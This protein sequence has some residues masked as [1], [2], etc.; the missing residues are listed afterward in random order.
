MG[1][2][3]LLAPFDGIV[4]AR[5]ANTW[6]FVL[7]STGDPTAEMRSPDLS[8]GGQAAPIYVVDRTDIVRIFVDIPERDANYVHIGSEARVKIWA[9]R[10]EWLPATVTRLSWALNTQS[11]TMRAEIDLPNTGSQILPGMYAYGEVVVERPD[12]RALPKAAFTHAGGKSFIWRYEK[13]HAARTEVQTG[14]TDG[15]WIEVTNRRV[16]S[17]SSDNERWVPIDC[18]RNRCSWAA[19][20]RP[21]PTAASCGS[22]TRPRP[23]GRNPTTRS[24]MRWMPASPRKTFIQEKHENTR[25]ILAK[26]NFGVGR[27]IDLGGSFSFFVSFGVFRG[28]E[29]FLRIC[30]VAAARPA[31]WRGMTLM[32]SRDQEHD[33]RPAAGSPQGENS[34]ENGGPSATN[35]VIETDDP[36]VVSGAAYHPDRIGH[37]RPNPTRQKSDEDRDGSGKRREAQRHHSPPGSSLIR[38]LLLPGIVSLICGVAGAWA[39]W[40]FFGAAKSGDQKNSSK[41]SDSGDNSDSAEASP[42]NGNLKQVEANWKTAL[43]ERDQAQAD[44][45]EARRTAA[46]TNA[47]LDFLKRKLLSAGRPGEVSLS[48]VFWAGGQGKD[49]S[50]RKAVDAAASQVAEVLADR[51][52]AEASVREILGMTYLN[53]GEPAQAVKQYER[54]LALREAMQGV[55]HPDTAEC[56]NRLA[57]AYR[58]ANRTAEAGRLLDRNLSSPAHAS[59]LAISGSMLLVEKKPA[60]AELKLRESLTIREK[61]QPDDWET[62]DTKSLL[63]EALV[64]QSK[65]AEAEPLLL[66]GYEGLKQR[67]NAISAPYKHHVTR[68]LERLVKLYETWGEPTKAAR[69]RNA[70]KTAEVAKKS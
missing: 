61:I 66:S 11:R 26:F 62:F 37:H 46:D 4:V 48:E 5:N 7:P 49:V 15:E 31:R 63:G 40:H 44:A 18:P 64:D 21:S 14:V 41:N 25:K 8:P 65:F 6:D 39:Y 27:A 45:S 16:E 2:L 29:A 70:L 69:W 53:L 47:I 59:A 28:Q 20:S 10:D 23:R 13:G 55:N 51:P 42:D 12:V 50:L 60:D 36:A 9:Y 17:K 1:Y 34:A 19:S 30:V 22:R 67:E 32:G 56:R 38:T 33:E 3:K 54:A 35:Q 68:A 52:M 43:K 57:V 58:L 24:R